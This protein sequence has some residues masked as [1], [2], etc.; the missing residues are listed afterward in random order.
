MGLGPPVC[1]NCML[2]G[3]FSEQKR[4]YCGGCG[5]K[6]L[7]HSLWEQDQSTQDKIEEN[8]RFI[9]IVQQTLKEIEMTDEPTSIPLARRVMPSIILDD[10]KGVS[11]MV[12]P[13]DSVV[14]LKNKMITER[15]GE[16]Q[17]DIEADIAQLQKNLEAAQ[18]AGDLEKVTKIEKQIALLE[19]AVVIY[20]ISRHSEQK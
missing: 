20:R 19:D 5:E 15:Q 9:D 7:R 18:T 11:P 4:W 14:N 8:T 16:G 17:V 2:M 6:S 12:G 13:I 1:L 10:I 3:S